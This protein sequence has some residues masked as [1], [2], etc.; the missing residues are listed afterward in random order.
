MFVSGCLRRLRGNQNYFSSAPAPLPLPSRLYPYATSAQLHQVHALGERGGASPQNQS[1]VK[2]EASPWMGWS[3]REQFSRPQ[4]TGKLMERLCRTRQ[5]LMRTGTEGS[6]S[7]GSPPHPSPH[8]PLSQ[9]H[10]PSQVLHAHLLVQ[11]SVDRF[12]LNNAAMLYLFDG[13]VFVTLL[14]PSM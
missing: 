8:P 3:Q 2:G 1:R 4:S 5:A 14:F 13:Y 9:P 10:S 7:T 11:T 6:S 12:N